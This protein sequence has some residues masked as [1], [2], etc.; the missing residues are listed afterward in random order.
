MAFG[1][2]RGGSERFQ[3]HMLEE[4]GD[5]RR[6]AHRRAER[7]P[8]LGGLVS[9]RERPSPS[10]PTR[11]ARSTSTSTSR[12]WDDRSKELV[13]RVRRERLPGDV[14]PGR[15]Q[16]PLRGRPTPHSTTT[17]SSWS[18]TTG[19]PT[20]SPRTAGDAAFYSPTFDE[21]GRFVYCVT[22]KDRE[23]SAIARID[24]ASHELEYIYAEDWDVEGLSATKDKRTFAFTVNEGGA[25]RLMLWDIPNKLQK[26]VPAPHGTGGRA[27]LVERRQEARLLAL[28]LV[29]E[30]RPLDV[31]ARGQEDAAR[32]PLQG[33]Y[34]L[35]LRD[36]GVELRG[37]RARQDPLVRRARGPLVPLPPEDGGPTVPS[38][39]PP[40]RRARVAV[41]ARLQPAHPVLPEARIRGPS[42]QLQGEH[43]I[44]QEVH[45]PRRREGED[46]HGQGRRVRAPPRPG[47]STQSTRRRSQLGEGATGASWSSPASTRTLGC[48]RQAWTSW[49][50]RTSSPS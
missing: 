9:R 8:Q 46:G 39:R 15:L 41:Q 7:H 12:T 4:G 38:H 16:D 25:S 37:A 14:E 45:P 23:F 30:L 33:H 22:D 34:L 27:R 32:Q 21:S 43:G 10:P 40:P 1:M 26:E 28:L 13:Y 5:S 2:D 24:V 49:G 47:A 31:R 36:T 6:Q 3:I 44:R 50:S 20:S 42:H 29:L 35:D 17:S 11:G 48:G 18:W 19:A